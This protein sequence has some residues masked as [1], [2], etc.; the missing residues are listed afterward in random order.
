MNNYQYSCNIKNECYDMNQNTYIVDL[1]EYCI[2]NKCGLNQVQNLKNNPFDSLFND[3][4]M[5]GK[6]MEILINKHKGLLRKV[7]T[8]ELDVFAN[9]CSSGIRVRGPATYLLYKSSIFIRITS[10]SPY[11]SVW[12]LNSS[13]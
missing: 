11:I 3:L 10:G 6:I 12:E 7:S 5:D 13:S 9:L 2:N 1:I 8:D 4:D